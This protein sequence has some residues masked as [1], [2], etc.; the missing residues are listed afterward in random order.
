[1]KVRWTFIL[2]ATLLAGPVQGQQDAFARADTTGDGALTPVE[3][4]AFID[5]LA[6]AGRAQAQKVKAAGRYG[7]A[8]DRIDRNGDGIVTAA[9]VAAMR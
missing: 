4:R 3:F 5:Q 6:E 1:M 9:E 8:F 2:A 7:L